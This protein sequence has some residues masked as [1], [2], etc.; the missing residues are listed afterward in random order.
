M[1]AAH[2]VCRLRRGQGGASRLS[3]R[4]DWAALAL[5]LR[6]VRYLALAAAAQGSTEGVQGRSR[7]GNITTK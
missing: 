3:P 1:A 5:V 4:S 6:P 7:A 2:Q